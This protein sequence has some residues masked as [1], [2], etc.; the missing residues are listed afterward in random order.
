MP[1]EMRSRFTARNG[2]KVADMGGDYRGG[3]DRVM[4][5]SYLRVACKCPPEKFSAIQNYDYY[6]YNRDIIGVY[7][8]F[9]FYP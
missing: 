5:Y 4:L 1:T 3:I 9:S 2:Q 6:N 8:E 7:H